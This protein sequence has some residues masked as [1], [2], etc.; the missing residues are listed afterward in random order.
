VD[1]VI[2]V[3][4]HRLSTSEIESALVTHGRVAEAAVVGRND[5]ITGQSIFAFV[6]LKDGGD[7]V[8]LKELVGVVRHAIGPFASPKYVCIVRDLPKTRSGKIVRR[9]LRKLV[10]GEQD[11]LGDLSTIVDPS[12]VEVLLA[13]VEACVA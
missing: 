7:P 4:G 11:S 10:N 13:K 2:N 5:D 3:S 12:V 1:D 8:E 6:T 9:V